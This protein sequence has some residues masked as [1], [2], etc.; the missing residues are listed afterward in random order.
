LALAVPGGA[1]ERRTMV[2]LLREGADFRVRVQAAFAL[3]N[4][5]DAS[6]RRPLE[7]ALRDD[8]PAV[9][10]A[11]ATGLGR[12]G[13][14]AALTALRR[15][16]SDRSA[17][18][19][20][21]V[22]RSIRTL[23]QPSAPT[24]PSTAVRPVAAGG[25]FYPAVNV[26]PRAG[27]INWSR[28]RYVV[29]LGDMANR[30]GFGDAVLGTSMRREVA[31][32]LNLL[33]GVATFPEADQLNAAARRQIRRRHI[34]ALRFDGSVAKLER[35]ARRRDLSIR[36]EVSM[37]LLAEP[38]RSLRGMLRGAATGS[39]PRQRNRRAQ[40]HRLAEEALSA[41]V[42]SAM[43]GVATASSRAAG[44]PRHGR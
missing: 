6:A 31:R 21:Q 40:E 14:S 19:R 37:M 32:N 25:G 9:R 12:L 44:G 22:E 18:V 15:A 13:R 42:R 10:A 7:R 41:A 3:G 17:A 11:A 8:N 5:H 16:R 39:E 23:S 38:G 36:C 29:V 28:V 2:R 26:I 27:H 1:Q 30:S 4:T 35:R 24:M 34:P 20:M 43:S 33:R